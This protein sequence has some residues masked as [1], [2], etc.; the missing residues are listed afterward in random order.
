MEGQPSLWESCA[1]LCL[2]ALSKS[3][4]TKKP[5]ASPA[6]NISR[7]DH[8]GQFSQKDKNIS[9]QRRH[10]RQKIRHQRQPRAVCFGNIQFHPVAHLGI[11]GVFNVKVHVLLIFRHAALTAG[12]AG[13]ISAYAHHCVV[14]FYT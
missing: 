11:E 1:H 7:A 6:T 4:T 10:Q 5:N 2:R 8:S 9:T 14:V 3:T 13:G 12:G